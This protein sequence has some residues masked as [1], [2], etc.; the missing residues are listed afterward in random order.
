MSALAAAMLMLF[1]RGT[2]SEDMTS[3]RQP[4][5]HLNMPQRPILNI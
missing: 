1:A 5:P 4:R 3:P 2:Y